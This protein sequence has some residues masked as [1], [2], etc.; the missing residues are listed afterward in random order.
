MIAVVLSKSWLDYHSSSPYYNW[1]NLTDERFRV[2]L[3][4]DD[5]MLLARRSEDKDFIYRYA[6][7]VIFDPACSDMFQDFCGPRLLLMN[8]LHAFTPDV[9][10]HNANLCA[11][12]D[13][14]LSAYLF[15][16]KFSARY[17]Y[18][19]DEWRRKGIFFPHSAPPRRFLPP[20][21]SVRNGRFL[22]S[23]SVGYPYACRDEVLA[24]GSHLVEHRTRSENHVHESYF[25]LLSEYTGAF[26]T[27]SLLNYTVA[28]YFEIPFAGTLMLAKRPASRIE[29]FLLGFAADENYVPILGEGKTG[30]GL[31]NL[32]DHIS[33]NEQDYMQIARRG[34]ELVVSQH[35][36]N[37]RAGYLLRILMRILEGRFTINDQFDLFMAQRDADAKF[38]CS[39]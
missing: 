27:P 34:H 23:G 7:A 5:G 31:K 9:A 35:T 10:R 39:T 33:S 26:A 24:A 18:P 13:Y 15:S 22:M 29:E 28:K 17:F 19:S 4:T 12:A 16:E 6:D 38:E 3:T 20:M 8:D 25:R 21:P 30:D 36:I 32:I 2:F 11:R 1:T 37:S 14:I